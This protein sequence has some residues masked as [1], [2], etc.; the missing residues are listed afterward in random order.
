[1]RTQIGIHAAVGVVTM[2]VGNHGPGY[3]TPGVDEKISLRTIQTV[4]RRNEH[5]FVG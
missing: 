4:G 3:G 1:M 2:A 5:G